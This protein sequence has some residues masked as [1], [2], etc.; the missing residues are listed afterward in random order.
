DAAHF[1]PRADRHVPKKAE[2]S[3]RRCSG[4]GQQAH[5]GLVLRESPRELARREQAQ[6]DPRMI[7]KRFP[8]RSSVEVLDA[9]DP[10][11]TAHDTTS[12]QRF[13]RKRSRTL[14]AASGAPARSCSR[15]TL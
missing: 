7:A 8:E 14:S 3:H 10:E 12:K 4:D 5:V 13:A 15:T 11:L 6:I 2:L 1:A 9:E